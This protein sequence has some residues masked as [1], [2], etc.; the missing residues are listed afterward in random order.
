M[1]V[2]STVTGS[3][4]F[5]DRA[6]GRQAQAQP[7]AAT[8]VPLDSGETYWQGQI[9]RA[10]ADQ[11]NASAT[12]QLRE[13]SNGNVGSL[14]TE[15]TF[16]NTGVARLQTS[17]LQGQYVVVNQNGNPVVFRNGTAVGVGTEASPSFEINAQ[18]LNASFVDETVTSGIG[19]GAVTDLELRSNRGSYRVALRSDNLS[20]SQ[21]TDIFAATRTDIDGDG[22]PEVVL[23][24]TV[25]GP[26]DALD[27]NFSGV[28]PGQYEIVVSPVS[29]AVTARAT[30]QVREAGP[31]SA[32][33]AQSVV[34]EQQGDN[35]TFT[36]DLQNTQNATL[37]V[38]S[39]DVNYLAQV[40]VRDADG[41]GQV[42]L[43]LN[44]YVAG[45]NVAPNGGF[46]AVGEDRITSYTLQTDPLQTPLD[47]G[48]YPVTVLLD[49]E[50]ADVG[51]LVLSEPSIGSAQVWTAPDAAQ[52]TDENLLDVVSQSSTV[53]REDWAIVQVEASGLYGYINSSADLDNST[54]GLSLNISRTDVGPNAEA[55]TIPLNEVEF[56]PDPENNQFFLVMDTNGL[57][58][59]AQ[60]RVN[61]TAT[62]ENP[63]FAQN[64]SASA[65]FSIVERQVTLQNATGDQPLQLSTGNATV[66]GDSTLAPGSQFLLQ[67]RNRGG[68]PFFEETEVTV[69]D[70]G[71]WTANLDIPSVSNRTNATVQIRDYNVSSD[72]VIVTGAQ[73]GGA[74]Q[75]TAAGGAQ[76]TETTAATE[77]TV[78]ETTP[79]ETTTVAGETT[80]TTTTTTTPTT[81]TEGGGGGGDGGIPGFGIAVTLVALL[82]AAFLAIRR[83][84]NR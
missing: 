18:E 28:S 53:A 68:E 48:Q 42:T 71:T 23:N 55:E 80:T 21:L 76:Q 8:V 7:D 38:G 49:G 63:Y 39:Q 13:W 79:A 57:E 67:V 11:T 59:G 26:R 54:F 75:T 30:I 27:A 24:R 34:S 52:P 20:A 62:E 82:A 46:T 10:S 77:T 81:T 31:Q 12:W 25:T 37:T 29:A 61:F 15:F 43:R 9:I 47:T 60:Y 69:G 4:A 56:V 84:Q 1:L 33:L 32:N 2:A 66:R 36:V 3:V 83:G 22:Q 50:T 6:N 73:T 17:N 45:R 70:N 74:Q 44:T 19:E 14:V 51:S 72:A 58:T 41:D 64:Q 78:A 5:V 40:G 16:N 35:A 65:N